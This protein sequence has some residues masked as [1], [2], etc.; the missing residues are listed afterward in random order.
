ME[1]K[2]SNTLHATP[3]H[4]VIDV[5]SAAY[6]HHMSL[7]LILILILTFVAVNEDADHEL[8]HLKSEVQRLKHEIKRETDVQ[9]GRKEGR[10]EEEEA[11]A[12]VCSTTH[13]PLS[14]NPLTRPVDRTTL[15]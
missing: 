11:A 14:H 15:A 7:I 2:E 10:K 5:S 9:E 8:F 1:G 12:F 13:A 6:P 3:P 4:R